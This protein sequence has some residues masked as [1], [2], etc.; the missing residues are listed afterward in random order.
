LSCSLIEVDEIWSYVQKKQA[1]VTAADSAEVGEAY[2][3]TAMDVSSRFV[4]S[5]HVGKRDQANADMFMT[6]LRGRLVVMPSI[7][8]DGFIPYV[9]AV[10]QSFGPGVDYSMMTKN[11]RSG[12]RADH[13]YE[14]SRKEPFI[15]KKTV[16]GAPDLAR[17]STAYMERNNATMRHHIGRMRRLCY[18]F[19]KRLPN[20]RTAVALN[21]LWYNVGT[22]VSTLRVTPAMAANVTDHIWTLDEF[23]AELLAAESCEKPEKQPLQ[24]RQPEGPARALP[25][26][27]GF[28]R[29]VPGSAAQASVIA[30]IEPPP[31]PVAA[32]VIEAPVVAAEPTGQLDLLSWRPRKGEQLRLF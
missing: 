30:P 22:V 10:G 15:T 18:A 6:D 8:S 23:L 13:R 25:E 3:F 16:F 17:T 9:A 31:A 5:F 28:L 20:H 11:Y 29:L 14:P 32:Q 19:S 2:T 26:G 21:Y 27:R 1:R 4:I 24:A 12:S 7:V